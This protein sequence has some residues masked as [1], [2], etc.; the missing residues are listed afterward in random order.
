MSTICLFTFIAINPDTRRACPSY[1]TAICPKVDEFDTFDRGYQ[2]CNLLET[3]SPFLFWQNVGEKSVLAGVYTDNS[4]YIQN[5]SQYIWMWSRANTTK[6]GMKV[7]TSEP[8]SS[9][10]TGPCTMK[11][12]SSRYDSTTNIWLTS[13]GFSFRFCQPLETDQHLSFCFLCLLLLLHMTAPLKTCCSLLRSPSMSNIMNG[14]TF[15]PHM[16]GTRAFYLL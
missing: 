16:H 7:W 1:L 3:D 6:F 2:S 11:W 5:S 13:G 12:L 10:S 8:L 15:C 9:H 14:N 4:P